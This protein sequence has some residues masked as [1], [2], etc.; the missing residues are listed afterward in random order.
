MTTAMLDKPADNKTTVPLLKV[1]NITKTFAASSWA[2]SRA[3]AA[4]RAVDGVSFELRE[5]ETLGL[6]GETGS[7]KSTIGRLVLRLL[8]PTS[9]SIEYEGR[10]ISKVGKREVRRMRNH[11]QMVFQDPLGSLDPRMTVRHLIAE[12]MIVHGV[13]AREIPGR[14]DEA[15]EQVGLNSRVADRYPHE[16]SGGQRQRIGIARAMVLRPKLLVL[17]EPV[18]ALD[19]SIQAQILNVLQD[20]QRQMR[21]AFLFIAHDL[22][23][24]RHVS[25]QVAVLYLGRI[26]EVG[27]RDAIYARPMHPYTSALLSAVPV[28]DPV[29]ER[30]RERVVLPGEISSGTAIPTGCR[31]HPRCLRARLLA[32]KPGI[33]TRD[34]RETRLPAVCIDDDPALADRGG[35]H[36]AACHFPPAN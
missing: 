29:K 35:R 33:A 18:S 9:G 2:F 31:F 16:F 24:V 27:P 32:D 21:V 10:D 7:G 14:I 30:A 19:V 28:P 22:A 26:I 6:V 23:V 25:D 8:D 34:A 20:I 36:F 17:D 5:G 4:V 12:P 1:T 11:M 15:M 13:P 3:S